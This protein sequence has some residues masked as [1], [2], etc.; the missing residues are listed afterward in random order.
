MKAWE[1]K[2]RRVTPY[3]PGEQPKKPVIKLNCRDLKNW[4]RNIS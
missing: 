1:D 2:I 4:Q 3:V